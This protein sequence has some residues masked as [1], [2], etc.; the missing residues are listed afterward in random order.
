MKDILTKQIEFDQ[1]EVKADNDEMLVEG[2]AST[3]GNTD[4]VNDVIEEG[5]F[6]KLSPN[7]VKFLY[8]HDIK[9]PIGVIKRLSDDSKGLHI[10][11]KFANTHMG[12]DVYELTVIGAIDA[13]SVGMR[14]DSKGIRYDDKKGIRYIEKAKLM[15]VSAVTFP[16][17]D[18]ARVTAVKEFNPMEKRGLEEALRMIGFSQK[19]ALITIAKAYPALAEHW[20][21]GNGEDNQSESDLKALENLL[22][23][24]KGN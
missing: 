20:N 24:I 11:A 3:Y 9:A 10:G 1:F 7:K 12:R 2:Y 19:E 8:Q 6:G 17:N 15:E 4:A 23:T 5:A 13:F 22:K 21:S 16:A 14:L 18:Q